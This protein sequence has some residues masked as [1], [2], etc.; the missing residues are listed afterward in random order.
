MA[1]DVE[2]I[3]CDLDMMPRIT[4]HGPLG[5]PK[6][7][8]LRSNTPSPS[9]P[10]MHVPRCR[11]TQTS[12]HARLIRKRRR[13]GH[14][15]EVHVD[16][17]IRPP[18]HQHV[19]FPPHVAL[20]AAL[21]SS[22]LA[23]RHPLNPFFFPPTHHPSPSP[24]PHSHTPTHSQ[25]T[26]GGGLKSSWG[27]GGQKSADRTEADIDRTSTRPRR[28]LSGL[29]VSGTDLTLVLMR[30]ES[31]RSCGDRDHSQCLFQSCESL[32]VW[33]TDLTLVC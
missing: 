18:L 23:H 26:C 13:N 12:C 15:H 33:D 11:K 21:T 7:L 28:A 27:R 30:L 6:I 20:P 25:P 4:T 14:P 2:I 5:C 19:A 8:A 1:S 22:P 9:L 10:H 31:A 17:S 16:L 24:M 29:A 3:T 32:R